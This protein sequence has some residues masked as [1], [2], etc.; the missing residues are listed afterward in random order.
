VTRFRNITPSSNYVVELEADEGRLYEY[1]EGVLLRGSGIP[2]GPQAFRTTA[3]PLP[4]AATVY[5]L[6]VEKEWETIEVSKD[7]AALPLEEEEEEVE[8]IEESAPS[9]SRT[10]KRRKVTSAFSTARSTVT[11][12]QIRHRSNY[13][14]ES[15]EEIVIADGDDADSYIKRKWFPNPQEFAAASR[16]QGGQP[17]E[18]DNR[19]K[20][21]AMDPG[22]DLF[23][24][25]RTE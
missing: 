21:I 13:D 1:L 20:D 17:G 23:V 18:R 14:E 8:I 4:S 2:P 6:T 16:R 3:T 22:N 10:V 9:S 15:D 19:I 24:V 5:D 11:D 25:A 7:D 12:D